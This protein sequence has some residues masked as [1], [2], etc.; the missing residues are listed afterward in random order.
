VFSFLISPF[1]RVILY[2]L[3]ISTAKVIFTKKEGVL[4][5]SNTLNVKTL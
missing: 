1:E 3:L 2:F 5:V 4:F